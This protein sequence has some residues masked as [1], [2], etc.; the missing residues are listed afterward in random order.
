M[1]MM[2]MIVMMMMMMDMYDDAAAAAA[3][4]DD[5]DDEDDDDYD[6]DDDDDSYAEIRSALFCRSTC[7]ISKNRS[8]YIFFIFW[9]VIKIILGE[10]SN[11]FYTRNT[12]LV[13]YIRLYML[14]CI[15]KLIGQNRYKCE[16]VTSN[17][18][19]VCESIRYRIL[20]HTSLYSDKRAYLL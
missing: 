14:V 1:M 20:Q 5:D 11:I 16:P 8:W 12:H 4:A 3:A 9:L 17:G 6:D 2:K 18:K 19:C 7:T 15:T 10:R 13:R